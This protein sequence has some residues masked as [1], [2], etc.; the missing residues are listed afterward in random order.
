V[1]QQT[2][3]KFGSLWRILLFGVSLYLFVLAL[4]MIKNGAGSLSELVRLEELAQAGG[5]GTLSTFGLGWFLACIVL[6]G[7]PVAALSLSFLAVGAL[8]PHAS[9]AMVMGSRVGAS[10]VVLAI[11]FLYD[12]R[13]KQ[14]K[15]GTY[16]GALA[17]LTTA[18]IYVPAWGVGSLLVDA[19]WLQQLD[20]GSLGL[21]SMFDVVLGLPLRLIGELPGWTQALA[22]IGLLIGAFKMFDVALPT[23]DPTG[24]ELG[25][26]ATTI[27]RPSVA[28]AL[29]MLVTAIT[30]S[31]SVSLTLLVPL[32]V[33]GIVRRENLIPFILGANITTFMDTLVTSLIVG[34]EAFAVVVCAVL[35]VLALSLPTVLLFYRPYEWCIDSGATWL[36][37]KGSRLALFVV[38]LLT[39]PF[40]LILLGL[41]AK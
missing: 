1:P 11:G 23:I 40:C 16:V 35:V 37:Q 13:S 38:L 2:R 7:S 33:R 8:T 31:V 14:A 15:G 9:F 28:F 25:R 22:G 10:F 27:Y 39:V 6:S 21:V 20:V 18:S 4:E 3:E 30:L 32:T 5:V 26:M 29:G 36:T 12:L 17:F 34:K 41:G 19:E 24:G